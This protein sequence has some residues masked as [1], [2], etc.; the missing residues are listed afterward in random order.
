[1][2]HALT[3]V[4]VALAPPDVPRLANVTFSL[5]V[6]LFTLGV[7]GHA[8]RCWPARVDPARVVRQPD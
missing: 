1:M 3:R 7:D 6:A 2:G 4:I 5:P 8:R